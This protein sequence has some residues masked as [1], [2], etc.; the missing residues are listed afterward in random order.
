MDTVKV[1][2]TN[3][4]VRLVRTVAET[5]VVMPNR[6]RDDQGSEREG[7]QQ[8]EGGR[9]PKKPR[10]RSGGLQQLAAAAETGECSFAEL[11]QLKQGR[12]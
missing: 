4:G 10:T 7:Q 5:A 8:P 3:G 12:F 2:K 9:P 1:I 11:L 6:K